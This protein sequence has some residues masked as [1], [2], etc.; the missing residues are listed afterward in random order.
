[1]SLYNSFDRTKHLDELDSPLVSNEGVLTP[2]QRRQRVINNLF[3]DAG[4]VMPAIARTESGNLTF[5]TGKGT[6]SSDGGTVT[7]AGTTVAEEQGNGIWHTTKL[8]L[9]AFAV[10]TSDDNAS[11]AIGA[12]VYTFPTGTILVEN[13]SIV[14]GVTA[15]I[16][17]TTNTPEVGLGTTIGTGAAATLTTT[18]EDLMDGGAGSTGSDNVAPD[19]A[20]G[21][22][23]KASNFTAPILI[24]T[25]GGKAHKLFL[26]VAAAWAN[27]TAAGAVTFTGVITVRWRKIT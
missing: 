18:M 27:V 20:G 19:V 5:A 3:G 13:T 8:T 6:L 22:L 2:L 7:T 12:E 9:T 15:A 11:L 21:T 16:S 23:Y 17:V 25:T 26:N 24:K 4:I 14:G 10:G 1:M